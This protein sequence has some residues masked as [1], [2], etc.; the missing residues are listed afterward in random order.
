[1]YFPLLK[2]HSWGK[3]SA[4]QPKTI[5]SEFPLF[6]FFSLPLQGKNV[7]KGIFAYRI[8]QISPVAPSLTILVNVPRN[9]PL[10]SSGIPSS[11][12]VSPS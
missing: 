11:F 12:V 6:L 2:P 1:M 9:L 4:A 8:K 7:K 5:C 10:T 3:R